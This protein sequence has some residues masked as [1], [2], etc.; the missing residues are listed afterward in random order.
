MFHGKSATEAV[1]GIAETAPSTVSV[2]VISAALPP[3]Y[4]PQPHWGWKVLQEL[5]LGE[6]VLPVHE[7]LA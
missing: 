4:R 1:G 3:Y 6:C 2:P 7:W 5:I